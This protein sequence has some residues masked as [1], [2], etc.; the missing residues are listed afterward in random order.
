LQGKQNLSPLTDHSTERRKRHERSPKGNGTGK[1][2]IKVSAHANLL[3][4]KSLR[5]NHRNYFRRGD[6]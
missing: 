2:P 1:G 4:E 3:K 6:S 5:T